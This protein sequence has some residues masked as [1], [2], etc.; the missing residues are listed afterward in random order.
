MLHNNLSQETYM[1]QRQIKQWLVKDNICLYMYTCTYLWVC[2]ALFMGS[3]DLLTATVPLIWTA[4]PVSGS[5]TSMASLERRIDFLQLAVELST[6]Y[7]LLGQFPRLAAV[8]GSAKWR[9]LPAATA[10]DPRRRASEM[11]ARKARQ[12]TRPID[13]I[14]GP[15]FY[16]RGKS[17][18]GDRPN[19]IKF[20]DQ[21][22]SRST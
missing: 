16:A 1:I 12:S 10:V 18:R 8:T 17:V 22:D 2:G 3:S 20:R 21:G 13:S 15:G 11:P 7:R 4:D 14:S 6:R 19:M 5:M 9:S